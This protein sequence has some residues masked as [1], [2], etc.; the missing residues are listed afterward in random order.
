MIR[1]ALLLASWMISS[2]RCWAA[3]T[4]SVSSTSSRASPSAVERMR[5][6]SIIVWL[7]ICSRRSI[8]SCASWMLRGTA[9]RSWSIMLSICSVSTMDMLVI[10]IF[11]A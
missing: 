8:S 2:E 9:T 1:S 3:F 4:N 6:A 11:L 7:T 10:G 5:R